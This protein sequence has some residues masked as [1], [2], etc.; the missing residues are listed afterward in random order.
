MPA[1][2]RYAVIG[3]PVAHSRSPQIHR[4]FA[5][6]CQQYMVYSAIDVMPEQLRSWVA[7]FFAASGCGLNVT[8]PHKQSLLTLPSRL[9][10]RARTAGALNTLVRDAQGQLLGDNTDGI[11][12]VRDLT[13]HLGV[14]VTAHR[15][16]VLGAGG[17]ARGVIAPLLELKPAQLTVANR[18][19]ERAAA[20][21]TSFSA[22]G[23][24]RATTLSDLHGSTYD[25]II[26]ATAA[27]LQGEVP[28][29][30]ASVFGKQSL[31]YDM[32]YGEQDTAFV[33]WAREHGAARTC[34][35]LGML[36]EQAAESFY[37][38]RGLRQ[39]TTSVRMALGV[40]P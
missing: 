14:T 24:V 39:N 21:A 30:P 22:L 35:G 38:W 13:E 27:S 1:P 11:G 36:I 37:A 29:V 34:S 28:A 8:V 7:K 23:P 16:L 33:R 17:A 31:C 19:I 12:L 3:H 9:S 18:T 4:L 5:Q 2:D 20:L 25:L 6:Q 10:E 15:V 26:N 40:T 32:G